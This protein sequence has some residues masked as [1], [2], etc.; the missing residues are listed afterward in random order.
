MVRK[1]KDSALLFQ[2][3]LMAEDKKAYW[4]INIPDGMGHVSRCNISPETTHNV[5]I[6]QQDIYPAR[7]V[8]GAHISDALGMKLDICERQKKIMEE[9]N[10]TRIVAGVAD[11]KSKGLYE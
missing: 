3:S 2:V 5:V 7:P 10:R 6:E 1:L 4:S 8:K 11:S 9:V